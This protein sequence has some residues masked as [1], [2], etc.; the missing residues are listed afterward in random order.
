MRA[1][2][3]L[4]MGALLLAA[5]PVAAQSVQERAEAGDAAAQYELGSQYQSGTQLPKDLAKSN[6]WFLRAALQGNGTAQLGLARQYATGEGA[7]KDV[8]TA[9]MW[10]E[11]AAKSGTEDA[12]ELCREIARGL[13][14]NQLE[15]ARRRGAAWAP[16]IEKKQ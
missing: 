3:W 13:D 12:P 7:G 6:Q 15:E 14:A 1:K 4:A 10:C 16:A 11:L 9:Y 8:V 2:R 5:L